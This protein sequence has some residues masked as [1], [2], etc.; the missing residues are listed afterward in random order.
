[1]INKIE[2]L[3]SCFYKEHRVVL[4]TGGMASGKTSLIAKFI[5]NK[6][7]YCLNSFDFEGNF[8]CELANYFAIKFQEQYP[9]ASFNETF[10]NYNRF[11]EI[12]NHYKDSNPELY[13]L[14]LKHNII[15]SNL[16]FFSNPPLN[17]EKYKDSFINKADQKI[18]WE[19]GKIVVESFL[20]D[21]INFIYPNNDFAEVA[22]AKKPKKILFIFDEIDHILN[23]IDV[24]FISHIIE[25][26]D[27]NLNKFENYDFTKDKDLKL[28]DIIDVRIIVSSRNKSFEKY[29]SKVE[30]TSNIKLENDD[31][32]SL[33]F[34]KQF[35]ASNEFD[36]TP[37]RYAEELF[38]KYSSEFERQYLL[39]SIM[40]KKYITHSFDLFPELKVSSNLIE[41]YISNFYFISRVNNQYQIDEE[42]YDLISL[43]M[44]NNEPELYKELSG[45]A[46]LN[47][48][49]MSFLNKMPYEDFDIF[50]KLAYFNYFDINNA[51]TH[52]FPNITKKFVFII[53]KHKNLLNK[54]NFH[55][56][57]KKENYEQ[58]D[59]FNKIVDEKN[60][61]ILKKKVKEIW[62]TTKKHLQD[63]KAELETDIKNTNLSIKNYNTELEKFRVELENISSIIF[64]EENKLNEFEKSLSP[65]KHK[66]PVLQTLGISFLSLVLI[67][68]SLIDSVLLNLFDNELFLSILNWIFRVLGLLGLGFTSK[69]IYRIY[70]RNR[71]KNKRRELESNISEIN[72]RIDQQKEV[73]AI[74]NADIKA[75]EAKIK[76][77]EVDITNFSKLIEEIELKLNEPFV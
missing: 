41:N 5:E 66:R 64:T 58:L 52:I 74:I 34:I 61:T 23:F 71:D 65:Y 40:F 47:T 46:N 9:E 56:S 29:Q 38:F 75:T 24:N 62:L 44:I 45:R 12:L 50:R 16:D 26:L 42:I 36:I 60:Y 39:I 17:I 21:L 55:L 49:F 4:L 25:H 28:S 54:N 69:S 76:E 51:I 59:K 63:K 43:T 73:K 6:N 35:L 57:V 27:T 20:V 3:D 11:T 19:Q 22:K 18:V 13:D 30:L 1:M 32:E 37:Y 8:I 72:T 2:E 48:F 70:I 15:K 67:I 68:S 10:F 33:P 7:F 53:D 77:L 14:I 31:I